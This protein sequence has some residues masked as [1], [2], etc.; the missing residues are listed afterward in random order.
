[1]VL[2]DAAGKPL[3]PSQIDGVSIRKT[4]GDCHDVADKARSVHF[5]R[6]A[7][8]ADPEEASCLT[9]HLG[10]GREAFTAS[11]A[12]SKT[13]ALPPTSACLECHSDM[14]PFVHPTSGAHEAM[15]CFECH[16]DAGH[17]TE[18]AASCKGCHSGKTDAPVPVHF[19]IPKLHMRR[20]ACETCHVR[21]LAAD[22]VPGYVLSGG[23]VVPLDRDGNAVH[24]GVAR[25]KEALGKKG[26]DDCHAMGS[27][28]FFGRTSTGS[29]TEDGEAI[30][31]PN[32]RAM[33]QTRLNV[34]VSALRERFLKPIS[35]WVFVAVVLA[36]IGHYLIFGPRRAD[37]AADESEVQRFTVVERLAHLLALVAFVLLATTGM[38]FLFHLESPEGCLRAVHGLFGP[39]FIAALIGIL[40]VWWRNALFVSC[41]KEWICKLGG[42]L[43]IRAECP[44]EKFNAGQKLFYWLIVI[45]AGAVVSLTGVMLL[46]GH[47]RSPSWVYTVHDV[48]AVAV[49]GG[50][51]GHAY[52]SILANPGTVRSMLTGR[53]NRSWAEHHHPNW[54][55]SLCEPGGDSG[56]DGK[57]D[58]E[59]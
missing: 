18:G 28:F 22:G 46:L 6:S 38:A 16:A 15:T 5:S 40:V 17:K 8:A 2:M 57:Q 37:A 53:V 35:G 42:Y 4:C 36:S 29:T 49:I 3:K 31:V 26:C 44:A 54:V 48:A 24:H 30:T 50:I 25:A 14:E 10:A 56:T 12:I 51:I 39:L 43:W 32:Y 41:D 34:V 55:K 7:G 45:L 11:G 27:R 9:C 47:G 20:L 13:P 52:L 23:R 19:G 21:K 59:P 58:H 33:R 1:V